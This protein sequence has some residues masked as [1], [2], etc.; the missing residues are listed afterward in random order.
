M[1]QTHIF[2]CAKSKQFRLAIFEPAYHILQ[3][4]NSPQGRETTTKVRLDMAKAFSS[5]KMSCRGSRGFKHY[6]HRSISS[7]ST[8]DLRQSCSIR[9]TLAGHAGRMDDSMGHDIRRRIPPSHRLFLH[10]HHRRICLRRSQRLGHCGERNSS[11]FSLFIPRF[12]N[13]PL[14]LCTS[15]CGER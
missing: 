2:Q 5:T 1:V 13:H 3:R 8:S 11:R 7:L 10:H 15:S 9:R 4:P 14:K 12:P 6:S